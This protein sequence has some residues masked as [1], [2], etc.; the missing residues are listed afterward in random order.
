MM[1][2][3]NEALDI[4]TLPDGQGLRLIG[5]CD[6]RH[7]E[8]VGAALGPFL[9]GTDD[10]VVDLSESR[11]FDVRLATMLVLA[12]DRLGP[13]RRLVWRRPPYAVRRMVAA[14]AWGAL[15][16]ALEVVDDGQR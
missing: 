11:F 6:C 8:V 2:F 16:D 3:H 4:E 13:G 7:A 15:P 14:G 10:V 12:A 1:I 5:D 9:G